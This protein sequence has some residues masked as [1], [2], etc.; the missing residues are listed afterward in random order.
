MAGLSAMGGAR[1]SPDERI[2]RALRVRLLQPSKR[3]LE[4]RPGLLHDGLTPL[5]AP[6]STQHRAAS[7]GARP[8][9]TG[10]RGAA[11]GAP[12]RSRAVCGRTCAFSARTHAIGH[13]EG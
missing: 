5:L 12:R 4:Q 1:A 3:R 10:E 13:T 6:L 8:L 2:Q 11:R 9:P 7:P